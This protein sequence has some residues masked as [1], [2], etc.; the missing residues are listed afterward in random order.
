MSILAIIPARMGSKGIPGKN[1]KG[2]AGKMLVE[3]SILAA[4]Q[5]NNVGPIC[6]TTDNLAMRII[7]DHWQI[8]HHKR[9]PEHATDT[10]Q[11]EDAIFDVLETYQQEQGYVPEILVLLQPTSPVRPKGIIDRCINILQTTGCDSVLTGHRTHALEWRKHFTEWVPD[12]DAANR[13]RRQD[14]PLRVQENGSVFV[15]RRRTFVDTGIRCGG[16]VE[17]VEVPPCNSVE[18]DDQYSWMLAEGLLSGRL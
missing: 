6:M 14:Q 18:T 8:Y 2:I 10:A 17:V 7:C 12:Y 13:C 9:K 1:F 3:W 15:T 11:I 5:S 4:K 16:K